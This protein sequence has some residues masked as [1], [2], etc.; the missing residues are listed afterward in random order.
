MLA[1][2]ISASILGVEG[3]LVEVE[4]D[5]FWGLPGISMVGLP[6]TAVQESRERVRSAIKHSGYQFPNQRITINMA[7]ANTR[8]SGPIFDLAIAVGLLAASE[9]IKIEQLEHFM[10]IGELSL[11]G[12]IRPVHGVLPFVLAAKAANLTAVLVPEKNQQEAALV[13][14]LK[15]YPVKHLTEAIDILLNPHSV[16]SAQF[17]WPLE[18]LP[19][20]NSIDYAEVKGQ[21]YAKRGLEIAA[22]GGHN[23]LMIGP[24]GSGKTMLARRLPTI[25]PPMSLEEALE[26]SKIYS[27]AGKLANQKSLIRDR[28]FRSPHHSVSNAGLIGG[29]SIPKPGE[30]SL[31]HH[32]VLFLD[33]LLEFR[34]EVLEVLRQPLEDACV[35]ISRAQQT[36]TFPADFMLI[37]SMNPC[38][39][40]YLGDPFRECHCSPRQIQRYWGRLS[41]P[42]LDRVDLHLE[43]P[44]LEKHDMVSRQKA[45]S[46]LDIQQRIIGAR[47][48]QVKRFKE[49][50]IFRNAQMSTRQIQEYCRLDSSGQ[51]IL[52]QAITF[53]SL[54]AR[55]YDRI[56]KVARTIADLSQSEEID[57]TH[58]SE[59]LQ[60]RQSLQPIHVKA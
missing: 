15:I 19:R 55:S 48:K 20:S 30:V 57:S 8:K 60:Y 40:G 34:R 6:D 31:A 35:T 13:N 56:L 12:S 41:G 7:P 53:L 39:C 38:P 45:E 10:L 59:A 4:V 52:D 1:K 2:T 32:G 18:Q 54:S 58:L 22:A 37:A 3:Y 49:T 29:S 36:L 33:E 44:R 42:L 26:T 50:G 17:S 28:P 11:D 24:P 27:V 23:L 14:G 25:L 16:S 47:D 51:K 9:Q 21:N 43:V 5:I 46:S